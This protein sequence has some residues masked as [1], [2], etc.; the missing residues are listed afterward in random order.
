MVETKRLSLATKPKKQAS[1]IFVSAATLVVAL[2]NTPI[3]IAQDVSVYG[4]SIERF[5]ADYIITNPSGSMLIREQIDVDFDGP[6]HGIFREIPDEYRPGIFKS[7]VHLNPEIVSVTDSEGNE[8]PYTE[9]LEN[10][11]LTL[12]IGDPNV[13]ITGQHQYN[14]AYNVENA[15]Q[16]FE[17]HDELF[18][19]INGTNWN[20]PMDS[21]SATFRIDDPMGRFITD[22]TCVTGLAGLNGNDCVLRN[23]GV[24]SAETIRPLSSFEN[25][26]VA[27]AFENGT[28]VEP[29]F[30]DRSRNVVERH[31]GIVLVTIPAFAI[32]YTIWRRKGKDLEN[33]S[34][35]ITQFDPPD[36]LTPAEVGALADYTADNKDV[37]AT[38][39]DL[40]IRGVIKIIDTTKKDSSKKR[41]YTFELLVSDISNLREHEQTLINGMFDKKELK[42]GLKVEMKDL[43]NS[44]YTT[45]DSIKKYLYKDLTEHKYFAQNPHTVRTGYIATGSIVLVVGFILTAATEARILGWTLSII[46]TG[47]FVVFFGAL[48]PKRTRKGVKAMNHV[49]GVQQYMEVAEKD[50]LAMMQGVESRYVGDTTAPEYTV[51]LYEK[52]LPFALVL[53][54][55][56]SWSAAFSDIYT[57]PPDWYQ[58]NW[59]TFNSALL[60]NRL[61]SGMGSMNTTFTSRPQSSGSSGF[62]GGGSGGGFG[63]GGGGSW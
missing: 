59:S 3:A 33:F 43:K 39:I 7:D 13:T 23:E 17:G 21:V 41:Q 63:G 25:M 53:G 24:I 36:H 5:H 9:E 16:F 56:K 44:F 11:F 47:A 49:R 29:G 34:P 35:T 26:S 18:W 31:A 40:A 52:L 2:L 37:T 50:R 46:L 54:V 57:Q 19:D 32:I 45:V 20:I 42:P 27:I 62:S 55:E 38:V 15:V 1:R 6:K 60:A 8:H 61:S 30:W 14:I 4:W 12:K 48:M 28:F 51:E 58:G 10:G 22:T